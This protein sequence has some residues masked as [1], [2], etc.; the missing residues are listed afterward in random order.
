[1]RAFLQLAAPQRGKLPMNDLLIP[2]QDLQPVAGN[3]LLHR[4]LFLA[5]GAGDSRLRRANIFRPRTI[6]LAFIYGR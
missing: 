1:M 4:R 5:R 3:G 2:A 6:G